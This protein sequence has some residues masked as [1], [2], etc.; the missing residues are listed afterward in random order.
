VREAGRRTF[1]CAAA[2]AVML[3]ACS[4][5]ASAQDARADSLARPRPR[6]APHW[7]LG[8][9]AAEVR[10]AQGSP[11]IIQRLP[12]L[13]LELW[14]YGAAS[15]RLSADSLR[16]IGWS[17]AG[18]TLRVRLAPGGDTT[19]SR[20]FGA[21][22]SRDEV[23]RLQGTPSALV[24]VI[25]GGAMVLMF[26]R[27]VVRLDAAGR[28]A[29]WSDAD[30]VLR[31]NGPPPESRPVVATQAS[32]PSAPA[33]LDARL[34]VETPASDG[35]LEAGARGAIVVD[36]TNRGP[37]R[38]ANVRVRAIPDSG[39]EGLV[40][41]E[42]EAISS[43]D[44]GATAVVRVPVVA[45]ADRV[46]GTA[47]IRVSASEANGFDLE[48]TRRIAIRTAALRPARF[49]LVGTRVEDQSGDG[50][51][52]PREVAEITARVWNAGTGEAR[53]VS[54]RLAPARDVFLTQESPNVIS[55]G[56]VAPRAWRDLSFTLYTNSRA[57]SLAVRLLVSDASGRWTAELPIEI[58]LDRPVASTLDVPS[59]VSTP[60]SG[61]DAEPPGLLDA[62]ERD[63]P[64]GPRN[65]DAMAVV[66]GVER[67]RDLPPARWA[68]RD[69]ALVRR[70][71]ID[72]LG[73]SDDR[74]HI[75]MRTD[76]DVT[77]N[78][79]RK[80]F[81]DDGWLARRVRPTTDLVVYWSGHGAADVTTR[82]PYLLP[83]DGDANYARETGYSLATLYEQL[84]RLAVRSVTVIVDACF[85]GLTRSHAALTPGARPV[86][87]SIEHP[88]LRKENMAVFAAAHGDQTASDYPPKRHGLFT[89]FV[90][91]GLRGAAD[92]DGDRRIT[93][94]ELERY[95]TRRV[96]ETAGTMDR[97][98]SPVVVARDRSRV[99]ARLP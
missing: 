44:A 42:A 94:A 46:A 20:A 76:A 14:S 67:Y 79:F 43:L 90:L 62:V 82:T 31:A 28:V 97:E 88:A 58:P 39:A 60:T 7:T 17:N 92:A 98:Q 34:R 61:G 49:E 69:A 77:G 15:V 23:L 37:G 18:R 52:S 68:A 4:S 38:A 74:N 22:A 91:D 33:T 59:G 83:F 95:A 84:A 70:Y 45:S 41:G 10:R 32:R 71:L 25:G 51:V 13:G 3:L 63:I 29:T 9:S 55:L 6:P 2:L 30:R 19:T 27:S 78:E 48:P 86:V 57:Q 89:Y 73:V 40:L 16:V 5:P 24:T 47:R 64:R 72:A 85:T 87:V 56:G 21:G 12:S 50:R 53:D 11:S 26:G 99:I 93:V 75:Y 8:S 35:L 65:P 80:L 81:A 36:I 1:G 54:V 96:R 66:L